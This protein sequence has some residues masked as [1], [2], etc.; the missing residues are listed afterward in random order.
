[1]HREILENKTF[2]SYEE[3]EEYAEK[4]SCSFNIQ[5]FEGK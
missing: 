4:Q 3:A 1:M 5:S 2:D